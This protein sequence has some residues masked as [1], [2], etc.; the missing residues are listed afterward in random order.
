MLALVLTLHGCSGP[1]PA[2]SG[3]TLVSH[4]KWVAGGSLARLEGRW[5]LVG[6]TSSPLALAP[7]NSAGALTQLHRQK[8][9]NKI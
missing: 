4:I 5:G 2:L 8:P 1:I 3:I 7:R 6:R 9:A